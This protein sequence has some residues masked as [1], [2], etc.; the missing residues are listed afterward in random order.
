VQ[1]ALI[2]S[3][4]GLERAHILRPGYAI[5]Y[6]FFDP[7]HLKPRSKQKHQ[8]LFFA[9]RSTARPDMRSRRAG[10]ARRI[11]CGLQAK[12]TDAWCPRRDEAYLGVLVDDL[13]TRGVA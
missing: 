7:R 4:K 6:D 9:G 13:V 8:G 12:G 11:E 2:R 3:I 1:L 10:F 5:E